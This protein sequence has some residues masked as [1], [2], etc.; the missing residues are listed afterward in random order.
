MSFDAQDVK[1]GEARGIFPVEIDFGMEGKGLEE[2]KISH[3]GRFEELQGFLWGE[4]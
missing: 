4:G 1:G 3:L 2:I